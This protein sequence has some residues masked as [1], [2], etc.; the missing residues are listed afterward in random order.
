M[1]CACGL[2]LVLITLFSMLDNSKV[3]AMLS[4]LNSSDTIYYINLSQCQTLEGLK[5]YKYDKNR[6]LCGYKGENRK[7]LYISVSLESPGIL[8]ASTCVYMNNV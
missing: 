3:T 2:T 8:G 5:V 6:V 4:L 1:Y 7:S